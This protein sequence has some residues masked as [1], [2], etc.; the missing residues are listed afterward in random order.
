MLCVNTNWWLFSHLQHS[1][2]KSAAYRHTIY[3]R[4]IQVSEGAGYWVGI[5]RPSPCLSSRSLKNSV[6]SPLSSA[7][8][9]PGS[10]CIC[11]CV[12][13]QTPLW[14]LHFLG[15]VQLSSNFSPSSKWIVNF[16]KLQLLQL[17]FSFPSHHLPNL[18]QRKDCGKQLLWISLT[19]CSCCML[20]LGDQLRG[21][22]CTFN[23]MYL[24]PVSAVCGPCSPV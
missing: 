22:I 14:Y 17:P 23:F 18:M 8:R 9:S 11:L 7:C 16:F 3:I 19:S 6:I 21:S 5:C 20:H 10:V 15:G 13:I 1:A 12:Y 2:L 24:H 4:G